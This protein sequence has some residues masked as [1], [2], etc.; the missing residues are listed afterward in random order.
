M[1]VT[2]SLESSDLWP[3]RTH[4]AT[5]VLHLCCRWA[6][7]NYMSSDSDLV[8]ESPVGGVGQGGLPLS[9][10]V[11]SVFITWNREGLGND[12]GAFA[13]T[14]QGG[15]WKE[16]GS[17]PSGP[18]NPDTLYTYLLYRDIWAI[19][20]VPECPIMTRPVVLNLEVMWC[21][22][23]T[24]YIFSCEQKQTSEADRRT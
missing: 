16:E 1:D 19:E 5:P 13:F 6:T 7:T 10:G 9:S 20:D 22:A 12:G 8:N 15:V 14:L 4:L 2:P 18:L 24:V 21:G 17:G 23:C 3:G 11:L